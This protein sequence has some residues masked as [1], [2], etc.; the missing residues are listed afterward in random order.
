[1]ADKSNIEFME[2]LGHV[3]PEKQMPLKEAL[4]P[5][6]DS[7]ELDYVMSKSNKATTLIANQSKHITDLEDKGHIWDF[8]YLQMKSMLVELFTLQGKN[9]RIK[10]FPYPR[11]FATL[12]QAFIWI[13]VF[14]LPFGLMG[15]FNSIGLDLIQ[16]SVSDI[17]SIKLFIF[18]NFIWLTIPFCMIVSWVF[19]SLEEVG[20][21]AEN[22]FEGLPTDVPIT[23]MSKGIEIDLLEILDNKNIPEP[24]AENNNVQM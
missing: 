5:Y 8:S 7:T 10:N 15:S 24:I 22:P 6:L 11:Q 9:E 3:I 1:M 21:T 16:N 17:S 14:I 18:Q 20:A 4:A 12:N 2:R 13:F 19:Y 23:T